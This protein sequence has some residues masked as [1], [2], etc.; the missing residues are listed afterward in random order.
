LATGAQ[1]G[2]LRWRYGPTAAAFKTAKRVGI[3][4]LTGAARLYGPLSRTETLQAEAA[5]LEAR[6]SETE[7]QAERQA[8]G[9]GPVDGL[10][11][12]LVVVRALGPFVLGPALPEVAAWWETH[13]PA[14]EAQIASHLP[15]MDDHGGALAAGIVWKD[16]TIDAT[17]SELRAVSPQVGGYRA[18]AV[19]RG[20]PSLLYTPRVLRAR[21]VIIEHA[22]VLEARLGG[23]PAAER[24]GPRR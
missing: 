22:L 1:G 3:R 12:L 13:A 23:R 20:R 4:A 19:G 7:R 11:A 21:L 10:D 9:L 2:G 17:R 18:V 8:G 15:R 14:V 6:V 24:R 5:G 16:G